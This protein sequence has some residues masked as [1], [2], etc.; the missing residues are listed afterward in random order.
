[1]PGIFRRG[2]AAD[3]D[4]AVP[5]PSVYPRNMIGFLKSRRLQRVAHDMASKILC[6]AF[7]TAHPFCLESAQDLS[8]LRSHNAD[9]FWDLVAVTMA[10]GSHVVDFYS[11]NYLKE[12]DRRRLITKLASRYQNEL[13]LG[14][15]ALGGKHGAPVRFGEASK[16]VR[17]IIERASEFALKFDNYQVMHIGGPEQRNGFSS[18]SLDYCGTLLMCAFVE[19]S[20]FPQSRV[21]RWEDMDPEI[22]K[23]YDIGRKFAWDVYEHILQNL[24][25]TIEAEGFQTVRNVA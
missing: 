9:Q 16:L 15:A 3:M 12:A 24:N 18:T 2:L 13:F 4:N 25:A 6:R 8:S 14:L 20:E 7:K 23:L 5:R 10:F 21:D 1:M 22:V 11:R 19:E 17:G